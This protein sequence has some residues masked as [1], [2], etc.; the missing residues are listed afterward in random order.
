MKGW[1]LE[2][3]P[4]WNKTCIMMVKVILR[5]IA[6]TNCLFGF[7]FIHLPRCGKTYSIKTQKQLYMKFVCMFF[8]DF[9]IPISQAKPISIVNL[10]IGVA[11]WNRQIEGKLAQN[12]S[13]VAPVTNVAHIFWWRQ[14]N[15]KQSASAHECC[16]NA[17]LAA[18]FRI[19]GCITA[20]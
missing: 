20:D 14:H 3:L 10:R 9:P 8:L 6:I 18:I 2:L 16:I 5:H 19:G 17:T 1:K 11:C 15:R 12:F 13:E 7:A 4:R